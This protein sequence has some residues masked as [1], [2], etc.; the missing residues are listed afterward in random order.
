MYEHVT[1]CKT[2][3][4]SCWVYWTHCCTEL[5]NFCAIRTSS[6]Q[7]VDSNRRANLGFKQSHIV[8]RFYLISSILIMILRKVCFTSINI[9][10]SYISPWYWVIDRQKWLV[11]KYYVLKFRKR[12][13]KFRTKYFKILFWQN[14]KYCRINENIDFLDNL[15]NNMQYLYD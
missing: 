3:D 14:G 10:I 8:F 11:S 7:D 4:E 6:T 9:N 5:F 13:S 1:L 2:F 12:V 15:F